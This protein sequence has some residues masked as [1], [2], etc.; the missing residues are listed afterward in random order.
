MGGM[1][2]TAFAA[3][4]AA[5]EEPV[6]SG[7]FSPLVSD[8]ILC[9]LALVTVFLLLTLAYLWSMVHAQEQT[10]FVLQQGFRHEQ[11]SARRAKPAPVRPA[12]AK[13]KEAEPDGPWL[14]FVRHYN[15]FSKNLSGAGTEKECGQFMRQNDLI[16]LTCI[17][18]ENT[19]LIEYS[20]VTKAT[21]GSFWAWQMPDDKHMF[22]VVPNPQAAYDQELHEKGGMKET[23]ASN[24]TEG[25]SYAYIEVTLPAL[26]RDTSGKW[27]VEQPGIIQ[28]S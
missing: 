19:G 28:L 4:E 1:A 26:V 5:G 10:I 27:T 2:R 12:K 23:F 14:D 24:Y 21:D 18:D 9:V 6:Y 16:A 20:P 22:A 17:K 11:R 3:G 8:I 15:S 13:A 25:E 7:L